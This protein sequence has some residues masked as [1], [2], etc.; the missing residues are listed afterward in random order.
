VQQGA[1]AATKAAVEAQRRYDNAALS[2]NSDGDSA[3]SLSWLVDSDSSKSHHRDSFFCSSDSDGDLDNADSGA[4]SGDNAAATTR[5]DAEN[6]AGADSERAQADAVTVAKHQAA[7]AA[8]AAKQR[9]AAAPTKKHKTETAVKRF[10]DMVAI[11]DASIQ[12]K[13]VSRFETWHRKFPYVLLLLYVS[14]PTPL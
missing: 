11:Q 9:A 5:A 1:S 7:A 2:R 14:A 3:E 13:R 4:G 12:V 10:D 8:N 6:S